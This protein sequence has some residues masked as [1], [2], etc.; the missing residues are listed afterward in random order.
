MFKSA[1]KNEDVDDDTDDESEDIEL[2]GDPALGLVGDKGM[3][4][5]PTSR[6]EKTY[7][8]CPSMI[9]CQT[10]FSTSSIIMESFE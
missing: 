7:F 1:E 4:G 6:P 2:G 8:S 10:W 5:V 3:A 9:L